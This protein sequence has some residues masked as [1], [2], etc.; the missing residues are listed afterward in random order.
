M[1]NVIV[2][3]SLLTVL[4]SCK[5]DTNTMLVTGNIKGLHQGTLYLEKVKDTLLVKVDS[6]KLEGNGNFTL[7]DEV[8]SAQIYFLS[9]AK[10]DKILQFFGENGNI[11]I[12]TELDEFG[13]KPVITGSKNHDL[14]NK[15]KE[16]ISKFNNQKLEWIK[17]KFDA[18]KTKNDNKVA[19]F[20][21]K[22]NNI[23]RRI[24]LYTANFAVNHADYEIAPYLALSEIYDATPKLLDTITKSMSPSVKKSIYGKKLMDY[25][26]KVNAK[27]NLK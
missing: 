6:I 8:K 5:K 2:I 10:S 14:M 22:I 16:T 21:K 17:E 26:K 18:S 11:N 20:N 3:I 4:L 27:N 13:F 19:E 9:L 23:P 25:M 24:Y 1:K 15:Y 7:T 12:I